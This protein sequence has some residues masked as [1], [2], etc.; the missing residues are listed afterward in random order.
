MTAPKILI[1]DDDDDLRTTL[2]RAL[3]Q[4]GFNVA[5]SAHGDDLLNRLETGVALVL[6][7]LNLGNE[8]GFE[9]AKRLRAVQPTVGLIM[10]TGR[11]DLVDKVVGLEIGADDYISKPFDL[12]ELLARIRSVL[13]RSSPTA[14]AAKEEILTF[15]GWQL[16][17]LR[18]RL[19]APDGREVALTTTEFEVLKLLAATPGQP[20]SRRALYEVV[21]SREWSPLER[22]LDTHIANLRRKLGEDG[23]NRYG[24]I[25]TVHGVGYVLASGSGKV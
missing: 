15:E 21:R 10:L 13:R 20:V 3:T 16:D 7:D 23:T 18:R 8:S 6:L 1:I 22:T 4:E 5:A 9:V 25:T 24:L 12:R 2:A 11:N 17:L 19:T 14:E